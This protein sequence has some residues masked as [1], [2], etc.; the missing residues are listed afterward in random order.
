MLGHIQVLRSCCLWQ[1]HFFIALLWLSVQI[2]L[3]S[4]QL[5]SQGRCRESPVPVQS[6]CHSP[7]C[8]THVAKSV[9]KAQPSS[10]PGHAQGEGWLPC[11]LVKGLC[12][13]ELWC[14][15]VPFALQLTGAH[16]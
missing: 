16:T 11:P 2:V 3:L 4:C 14:F 15:G 7:S 12:C 10:C 8:P 13:E 6:S 5:G 9:L 1:N